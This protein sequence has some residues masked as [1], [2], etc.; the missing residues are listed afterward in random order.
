MLQERRAALAFGNLGENLG[1]LVL[2]LK[3]YRIITRRYQSPVGEIDIIARRGGS[4]VFIEVKA[5]ES[6]DVAAMSISANQQKRI[7]RAAQAFVQGRNDLSGLD[8][9]FDAL[10]VAPY[11]WPRHIVDAWRPGD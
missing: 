5:R 10:L 11:Q 2:M 7:V 4:L 1:V 8:M 9:R 6:M 3:G